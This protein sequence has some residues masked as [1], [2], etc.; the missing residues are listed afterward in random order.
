MKT[1]LWMI[2]LLLLSAPLAAQ[3]NSDQ[4]EKEKTL[5]IAQAQKAQS[6]ETADPDDY[7]ASEEISED[8][9]VSYPVDI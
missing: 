9:S 3:E 7:Q 5:E 8:L 6:E 2:G 4:S 1:T